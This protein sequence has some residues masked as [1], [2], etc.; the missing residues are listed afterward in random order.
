MPSDEPRIRFRQSNAIKRAAGIARVAAGG[1]GALRRKC[2]ERDV[3]IRIAAQQ[4]AAGIVERELR[5]EEGVSREDVTL[6]A[7]EEV[8][9]I[10]LVGIELRSDELIG[11][12]VLG[13]IDIRR[14]EERPLI[15]RARGEVGLEA[16]EVRVGL[17]RADGEDVADIRVAV[18]ERSEVVETIGR[19]RTA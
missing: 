18:L 14:A 17:A 10:A 12:R 1:E 2:V 19:D 11:D 8:A 3:G 16:A 9:V 5:L 7:G 6:L 4:R 15:L 13:A